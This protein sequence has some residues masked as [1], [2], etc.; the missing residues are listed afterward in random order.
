MQ[1]P[2]Q[3]AHPQQRTFDVGPLMSI[4]FQDKNQDWNQ[5]KPQKN[6]YTMF[7]HSIQGTTIRPM[8]PIIQA[9]DHRK[10][11]VSCILNQCRRSKLRKTTKRV[12]TAQ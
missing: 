7:K 10:L 2:R 11:N 12:A 8:L 6:Y 1:S 9:R 4:V 5:H 3:A